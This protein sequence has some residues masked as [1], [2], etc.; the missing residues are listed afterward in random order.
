MRR[1]EQV[2]KRWG[3]HTVGEVNQQATILINTCDI[4]L[5]TL[6]YIIPLTSASASYY[7][8]YLIKQSYYTPVTCAVMTLQ[9]NT[10]G[11]CKHGTIFSRQPAACFCLLFDCGD[12]LEYLE[13]AIVLLEP[14]LWAQR[15]SKGRSNDDEENW[16]ENGIFNTVLGTVLMVT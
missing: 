3:G 10:Y 12:S 15:V 7:S 9:F 8:L 13:R 5:V 2:C 4:T 6:I 14:F 16:Q 11:L 1:Q